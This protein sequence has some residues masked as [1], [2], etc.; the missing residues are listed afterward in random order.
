MR[1]WLRTLNSQ[2]DAVAIA[3]VFLL[4]F[5][6]LMGGASRQ[7][8]LRLA[9]VELSSLPLLVLAGFR[10]LRNGDREHR[11]ALAILGTVVALPLLQLIPLPPAIW[12][13]LPGRSEMVLAL[14]LSGLAPEWAPLSVTPDRTWRSA[15]ALVPPVA[16][17]LG[18]LC[19]KDKVRL[20]LIYLILAAICASILLGAA[21]L[22][23]GS[24]ALYLWPTTDA[25]NVVG[26]MANRNHMATLCLIGL[27]F[28]AA[29]GGRALRRGR[30]NAQLMIWFAMLFA[31]LVMIAIA[32]IRSRAG[33]LLA[34]PSLGGSLVVAW[35]A[36][37]GSRPRPA[38]L[39]LVGGGVVAFLCVAVLALGPLMARFDTGG[40]REGRFENW[41]VVAEAATGYLPVGSGAGSFDAVFRS[42]EPL[43][44]L[45][46]TF[47]NQAH[48]D[49]LE[50]WLETGWFG[51]AVLIPFLIWLGRRS[52]TAWRARA[53]TDRDLQR[54]ASVAVGLILAHSLVDYPLRTETIAVLFALCCGVLELALKP[55]S[56]LAAKTLSRKRRRGFSG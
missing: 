49:Y 32:A 21:Q 17:F 46:P 37:S 3:T 54:A 31:G 14:N 7:H 52:W 29:L 48:N 42:V 12:T 6:I 24:E 8:E 35:I 38:A 53:S 18:V 2:W 1:S 43:A 10:L 50:S 23:S 51:L 15:L 33:L 11:F 22:A 45:D 30:P 40:A 16:M 41:P 13:R 47:F 20:H 56:M 9:L 4:V 55:D 34:G 39:A 27:P 26:F 5:S 19:S 36:S 44:Q 25:G 28:A